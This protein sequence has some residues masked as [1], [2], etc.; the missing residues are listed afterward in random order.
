MQQQPKPGRRILVR[1]ALIRKGQPVHDK[2]LDPLMRALKAIHSATAPESMT[3]AD[4]ERERRG[5]E[6]LGRLISPPI[7]GNCRA[8]TMKKR[9]PIPKK[10]G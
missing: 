6:V 1:P 9:T 3:P 8:T 7:G 5:Q 4:L 10:C 2:K